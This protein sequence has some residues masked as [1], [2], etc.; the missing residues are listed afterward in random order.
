MPGAAHE[1]EGRGAHEH[2]GGHVEVASFCHV[3]HNGQRPGLFKERGRGLRHRVAPEADDHLGSRAAAVTA[4]VVVVVDDQRLVNGSQTRERVGQQRERPASRPSH[5]FFGFRQGFAGP[6]AHQHQSG[7]LDFLNDLGHSEGL[8]RAGN[9]QQSLLGKAILHPRRQSLYGLGL[10][11]G[12]L[13]GADHLKFRHGNT[14]FWVSLLYQNICSIS[15]GL[16]NK[17]SGL[18]KMGSRCPAWRPYHH[19]QKSNDPPA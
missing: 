15:R 13:K 9:A 6:L 7:P 18:L 8:A 17:F 16:S 3:H 2:V 11:A 10:V 12:G 4:E 14:S 1:P 5:H 19:R